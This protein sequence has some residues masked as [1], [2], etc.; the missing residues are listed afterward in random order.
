MPIS[1]MGDWKAVSVGGIPFEEYAKEN[2][3]KYTDWSNLIFRISE[4]AL[5]LYGKTIDTSR[6][7]IIVSDGKYLIKFKT[8]KDKDWGRIIVN[9]DGTLTLYMYHYFVNYDTSVP[10][11]LE[12]YTPDNENR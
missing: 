7:D 4:D 5:F 3:S 1:M 11:I 2:S 10:I 9:D 12:R 6:Y 8:N